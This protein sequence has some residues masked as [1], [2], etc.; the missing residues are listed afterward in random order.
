MNGHRERQV[1]MLWVAVFLTVTGLACTRQT[2]P[3]AGAEASNH[4]PPVSVVSGPFSYAFATRDCAPWDGP[5][6]VVY[7]LDSPSDAVPPPTRHVRVTIWKSQAEL[8][9]HVFRWPANRDSG[10]A[11]LCSS[12]DSCEP[13]N[14]GEITFGAVVDN[15]S[16]EGQLDLRFSESNRVRKAFKAAWR[17]RVIGCG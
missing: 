15:S 12:P 14:E 10:A 17:P 2:D 4:A 1:F 9:R 16:I 5:A 13:A 11:A 6:V 8:A 7:L 3:A